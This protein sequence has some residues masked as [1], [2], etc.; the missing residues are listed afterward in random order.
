MILNSNFDIEKRIKEQP[1]AKI[2]VL[3]R[4]FDNSTLQ[5]M[6][7]PIPTEIFNTIMEFHGIPKTKEIK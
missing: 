3:A 6:S 1:F 2:N 7:G 4:P 5:P